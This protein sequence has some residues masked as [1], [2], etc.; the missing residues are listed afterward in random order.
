MNIIQPKTGALALE[1]ID[2]SKADTGAAPPAGDEPTAPAVDEHELPVTTSDEF[3]DSAVREYREGHIDP[4]LWARASA[5]SGDDK[6]LVIAAYLRARA[7]VLQLKKRDRPRERRANGANTTQE[8]GD[9]KFEPESPS[10]FLSTGVVGVKLRGVQL[11]PKHAVAAAAALAFAVAAAWFLASPQESEWNG[12][13]GLSAVTP[14]V[15]RRAPARPVV[16]VQPGV[17]NK[18]AGKSES[19][20]VTAL[21]TTMQQLKDDG[22]WNVL[23]LY[24]AKWTRE[25]PSNAAAWN[26]LSIGY[27]RLHQFNEAL[28]AATK[29][30]E[31]SPEDAPLWRNVG[32]LNLRLDLLPEAGSAFDRALA[33]DS[34]DADA[35]CG[36]AL[37]AR[38][39]GRTK[40]ADAIARRL[41]SA[42]AGCQA[43]GDGE[44][45]TVVVSTVP[46]TKPAS[47]ARR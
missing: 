28:V 36:A 45:V 18:G 10:E 1:P 24:A 11:K 5:Q 37:V 33:A 46:A 21:K 31:L 9:R 27:T 14:S 4:T 30:V 32:H 22:N 16:G 25:E 26:E 38:R 7:T 17:A 43:L 40:D 44:S 19:D 29:A 41:K 20:S 42:D 12:S 13:P 8:T 15:N 2:L 6:S 34:D 3:L 39:Q 23:V 47:S 35:L